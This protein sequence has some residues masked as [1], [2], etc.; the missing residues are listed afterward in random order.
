MDEHQASRHVDILVLTALQDELDAV[1]ALGET[2]RTGWA[3]SRDGAGFRLY[4]RGFVSERGES[5][6]VAAAWIGEKGERTAAIRGMQL[7][8]EL[9]PSCLAMC[10]VCAGYPREVALGD[11]IVAD[12]IWSAHEGKRTAELGRPEAFHHD[13]RMFDLEATWKMDAAFLAREFDLMALQ[14]TRPLSKDAQRRWILHTLYAHENEGKPAPTA[15]PDRQ[16]QCP[17]WTELCREAQRTELL[18]RR[19][20]SLTLTDKGKDAVEAD[21]VEYPDGLPEDPRMQVHVGAIA[22]TSAVVNDPEIFERLRANVGNTLG[23]EMEGSAIGELAQRFTKRSILV[24][25]VQDYADRA[26]DNAFRSFGCRAAAEF[27]IAFLRKHFEPADRNANLQLELRD[28]TL[29]DPFLRQVERVVALRHPNAKIR[30]HGAEPPFVGVLEVE[31][32][33]DGFIETHI[34]V[35]VDETITPEKVS[36]FA[37]NVERPYRARHPHLWSTLVHQGKPALDEFRTEAFRQGIKIFTFREYQGLFD[38]TRYLQWQTAQLDR[39]PRYPRELYVDAPATIKPS[40]S[41]DKDRI[42]N[43]LQWLC[44][45]L[46]TPDRRRFALVLG[47]FGVG[48][49]FLLRELCRRLSAQPHA[50][51]PVLV[52]MSRLEKHHD[53]P[54][55]LGAHFS[56]ADVEGYNY[57]AFRYML[58]E[59][60][61]ALLFDGFDELAARVTY[62][63]ATAHFDTILS[64]AQGGYAKVS[65]PN[66][67]DAPAASVEHAS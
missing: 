55:I 52:E 31:F 4:K 44:E 18:A 6:I 54:E 42:E 57:P 27:L 24:K 15:H 36:Q 25:A 40:G 47:E 67:T 49:T 64:A 7:L 30:H 48:K 46:V 21:L 19:G 13:P 3:E 8:D 34:V 2:G 61:I 10:G 62:D 28:L 53:L 60:R 37:R 63:T 9:D 39:D 38:L 32:A 29:E 41:L 22:T 20:I 5:F 1:L 66:Q 23:L 17:E 59:G 65:P 56:R 51:W 12:Q 26:T 35:P 16:R 58:E 33:K 11:I 50:V 43:V 14:S 45:L